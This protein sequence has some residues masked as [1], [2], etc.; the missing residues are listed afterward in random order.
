LRLFADRL[1]AAL[2]AVAFLS[3]YF[4]IDEVTAR[5]MTEPLHIL[6]MTGAIFSFLAYLRTTKPIYLLSASG[7]TA[8]DYL[9]RTNGL[10]EMAAMMA[11]LICHDA[12][13]LARRN[14][15]VE[16]GGTPRLTILA[17]SYLGA[18]L[19]FVLLTTPSWAPRVAHFGNP[20][21]HGYLSNFLWTD[22]YEKAHTGKPFAEYHFSDYA[23]SHTVGDAIK[24]G[25]SGMW[26]L[27]SKMP[28][29]VEVVPILYAIG[30]FG[31]GVAI[32]KRQTEF[33]LLAV[34]MLLQMLPLAWTVKS[35]PSF[36]VPYAAMLP[37]ELVFAAVGLNW[38]A[39]RLPA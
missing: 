9:G 34:F 36:R 39:R 14:G 31:I 19:I 25:T 12:W 38:L 16:Q 4:M 30:L 17:A 10:F 8:L 7:A 24:R 11:A 18:A 26:T 27:C 32:V 21:Y 2:V 37:F 35:G 1:V 20:I 28:L 6:L 33:R 29:R 22:T 23:A 13:R 5:L 3:N 15:N